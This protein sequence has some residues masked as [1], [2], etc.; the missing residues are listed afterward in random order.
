MTASI[1][2]WVGV[3]VASAKAGDLATVK[4]AESKLIQLR[5][6]TRGAVQS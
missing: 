1:V 5:Q 2:F 4:H 6:I 3:M